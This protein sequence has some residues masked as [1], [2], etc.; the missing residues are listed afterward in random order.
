MSRPD[1]SDVSADD[2]RTA[3]D[4]LR[5]L[6]R[7]RPFCGRDAKRHEL[8]AIACKFDGAAAGAGETEDL[9]RTAA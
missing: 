8:D 3:A 1:L 2:L 5:E 4:G 9:H 6:A 7:L